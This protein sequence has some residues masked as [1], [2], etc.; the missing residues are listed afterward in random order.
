M[1]GLTDGAGDTVGGMT[2]APG[3]VER[4]LEALR[5]TGTEVVFRVPDVVDLDTL[6]DPAAVPQAIDMA[7][8]QAAEDVQELG[9]F[10]GS[11]PPP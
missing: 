10:V 9:S 2:V 4:E 11:A 5:A 6:M 3:S 1:L 8:R 7:R